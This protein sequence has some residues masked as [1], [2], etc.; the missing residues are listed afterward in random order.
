MGSATSP[1]RPR[2]T[3]VPSARKQPQ[4]LA[5]AV[6]A[7]R[8]Q[9][10]A[11]LR[12]T[13]DIWSGFGFPARSSPHPPQPAGGE[14]AHI[15]KRLRLSRFKEIRHRRE[16]NPI[17]RPGA[18]SRPPA[19][20]DEKSTSIPA[21]AG[22]CRVLSPSQEGAAHGEEGAEPHGGE[23]AQAPEAAPAPCWSRRD[24]GRDSPGGPGPLPAVAG[25]LREPGTAAH[26]HRLCF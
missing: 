24:A 21:A 16:E 14:A 23:L 6:P 18:A 10:R 8:G 15:W 20:T 4:P 3:P 9:M 19:P 13:R 25:R 17:P 7:R 26:P 1:A 22:S 12:L 5:L 11:F 2:W